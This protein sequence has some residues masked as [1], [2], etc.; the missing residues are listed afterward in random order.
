LGTLACVTFGLGDAIRGSEV[1]P[2]RALNAWATDELGVGIP[3]RTRQLSS[4]VISCCSGDCNADDEVNLADARSIIR[5]LADADGSSFCD[6]GLQNPFAGSPCCDCNRDA[7][8]DIADATC[9]VLPP[10]PI[11][12]DD[13]DSSHIRPGQDLSRQGR[14]GS[15]TSVGRHAPKSA[16]FRAD[17]VA[18]SDVPLPGSPGQPAALAPSGGQLPR[19]SYAEGVPVVP[20]GTAVMPLRFDQGSPSGEP[21]GTDDITA[22]SV[23]TDYDQDNL[24]FDDTDSDGDGIPDSVTFQLPP[25]HEG[26]VVVDLGRDD[27]ELLLATLDLSDPLAVL[28]DGIAVEIEFAV[29]PDAASGRLFVGCGDLEGLS[30]ADRFAVSQPGLCESGYFEIGCGDDADCDDGDVC[31]GMETCNVLTGE[32]DPGMP[33]DCDDGVGCTVDSCDE[34]AGCLH[35][36]DDS[37]CPGGFCDPVKDCQQDDEDPDD[38]QD[39]EDPDDEQDDEDPDDEQDD[40]DPDD[41]QDD[42]DPDDEC[43]DPR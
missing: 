25:S 32:C 13:P 33:L 28:P 41:E 3:V 37:L 39:D 18:V 17:R 6:P 38:E 23:C 2:V 8:I 14:R 5:E 19:L 36:P 40:E 42:E 9:V 24:A 35:T 4:P 16:L 31:N 43:A 7:V 34:D 29:N 1:L 20:G 30:F 10:S 27:C 26:F 22:W 11:R 15:L 21:G 12:C